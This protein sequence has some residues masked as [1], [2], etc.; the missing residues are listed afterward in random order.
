M[1]SSTELVTTA[2]K[3]FQA[4]VPALAKL[5]LV[6]GLELTAGGLTGPGE[7]EELRIEV[8]GPKVTQGAPDDAR[9]SLTMPLTMFKVLAEEG[10]LVDWKE[11][12]YY[13]H[14]KVEGDRRIQKLIGQAIAR[15]EAGARR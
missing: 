8:P 11:A 9:L 1:A 2:V 4:E 13:G 15:S 12:F 5:K 3:R 6:V 14:L 7:S 10:E